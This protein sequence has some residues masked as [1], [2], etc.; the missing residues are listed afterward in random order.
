VVPIS[1]IFKPSKRLADR[2]ARAVLD[3]YLHEVEMNI[4][5]FYEYAVEKALKECEG[6]FLVCRALTKYTS[7]PRSSRIS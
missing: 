7:K 3:L 1:Y 6:R 4:S 2:V 5:Q